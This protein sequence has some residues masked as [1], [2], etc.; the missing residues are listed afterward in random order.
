MKRKNTVQYLDTVLHMKRK[1]NCGC[2]YRVGCSR[3]PMEKVVIKQLNGQQLGE[4]FVGCTVKKVYRFSCPQPGCHWQKTLPSREK[5]NYS[6]SGRV[7]SV[8]PSLRTG[9]YIAFFYSVFVGDVI[10][11][12]SRSGKLCKFCAWFFRRI[13]H[14]V[15][16]ALTSYDSFRLSIQI[17][18]ASWQVMFEIIVSAAIRQRTHTKP[19]TTRGKNPPPLSHFSS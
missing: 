2:V 10:T 19:T 8:T 18:Q 9:K 3:R 5:Y 4:R 1:W 16:S 7:C 13:D 15:V 14:A 6:R 17:L 11:A 12:P